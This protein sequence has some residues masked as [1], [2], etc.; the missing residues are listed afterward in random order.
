VVALESQRSEGEG[1][2]IVS[3]RPAKLHSETQ[4]NKLKT[5]KNQ[6]TKQ[7]KM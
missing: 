7:V 3:S 5:P 1:R 4:T 2:K 6:T